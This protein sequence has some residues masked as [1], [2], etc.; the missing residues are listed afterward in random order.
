[1]SNISRCSIGGLWVIALSL[2]DT[3]S[4]FIYFGEVLADDRISDAAAYAVLACAMVGLVTLMAAGPAADCA[5]TTSLLLE[6]FPQVVVTTCIESYRV[7]ADISQVCLASQRVRL[8]YTC[9]RL[10]NR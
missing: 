10:R 7:G 2:A 3:I 5:L 9:S 8:I 1:M 6:D 4:D